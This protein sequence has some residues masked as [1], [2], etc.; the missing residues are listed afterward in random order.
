[1][2]LMPQIADLRSIGFD[3]PGR[4]QE[5]Y[6]PEQIVSKKVRSPYHLKNTTPDPLIP[7]G[8]GG[9]AFP[10]VFG[11]HGSYVDQTGTYGKAW[12]HGP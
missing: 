6:L 9:S 10:A 7:I 8:G 11:C 3:S 2:D 4:S 5:I 12:N 1:M